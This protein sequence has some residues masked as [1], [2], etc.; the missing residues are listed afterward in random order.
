[1]RLSLICFV[2]LAGC[3]GRDVP[4]APYVP[5]DLLAPVAGWQGGPPNS[6]GEWVDAAAAEQRGLQQCNGDKLTL[7]QLLEPPPGSTRK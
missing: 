2:A 7:R 1:M 6:E 5:A 4:P 3:S